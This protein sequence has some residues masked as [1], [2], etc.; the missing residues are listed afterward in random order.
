MRIRLKNYG[1][2]LFSLLVGL[3]AIPLCGLSEIAAADVELAEFEKKVYEG[4]G[5]LPYRLYSPAGLE[6]GKQVPLVVYLHGIGARGDDNQKQLS[7]TRFLENINRSGFFAQHPCYILAPQ[8]AEDSRWSGATLQ[9]LL[10]L[11]NQVVQMN[12]VDPARVYLTG[13]S[14]GGYGTWQALGQ[15]PTTFAAAVPVCGGGQP[16][17]AAKYSH[18]PIWVFHG[19]AD[20]V[21][22]PQ[23]SREMVAALKAAGGNPKYTELEGVGHNSW[24][25]AYT[26]PAVWQWMF[27][28]KREVEPQ[29]KKSK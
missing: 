6:T 23:K 25:A 26:D 11:I 3:L 27:H 14:M 1:C 15:K 24:Q 28:Q 20:K 29:Q 8:C 5:S 10:A 21:V 9:D 18:V 13:Q 7:A 22:S 17:T 16:Q 12:G 4:S 19:S 2:L